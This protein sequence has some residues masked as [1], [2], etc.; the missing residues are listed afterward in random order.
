MTSGAV[1]QV[2]DLM[3]AFD[4]GGRAMGIGGATRATDATTQSALDNPAGLAF[5]NSPT[6]GVIFRNL[7]SST[8]VASGNFNNRDTTS[9][10]EVGKL[11]LTH[12]G[13]A[14]PFRGGT[15]GVSYTVG[16]YADNV[17]TGNNLT[18]GGLSAR[19]LRE[20]ISA[21]TD[22]FTVAYGQRRGGTNVGV[23][24]VV[25]SQYVAYSQAY[26]L[27]DAGNNQVGS[28]NTNVSGNG[29]G[30]GLVAGIQGQVA[31]GGSTMWGASVRTPIDLTSNGS[32]SNVYDKI[33]GKFSLGVAG[34]IDNGGRNEFLVWAAQIDY[35]FGGEGGAILSRDNTIAGSAGVEYNLNWRN[36]RIPL[37]LG[38]AFV[39]S[40]GDGFSDRNS[41]T[42]GI[43]YRPNGQPYSLDLNF[44]K[45]T[46]GNKFDIGLGFTYRPNN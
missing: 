45:P 30:V 9:E 18:T 15:L 31:N 8:V 43:G 13:Y 21:K 32:T 20:G 7:P 14:A 10:L 22:F 29:I 40:G 3:N 12:V 37:R 41:F 38:Y 44:A 28:V 23:G 33:P 11:A 34:R 5:V 17:T 42:I 26:Q 19:N 25:A 16:G 1:A 4:T 24:V 27:F 35:F 46:D 2:P 36:A 6:T 39:P